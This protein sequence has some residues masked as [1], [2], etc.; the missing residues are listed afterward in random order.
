VVQIEREMVTP[1]PAAEVWAALT[2]AE[3]L[4]EWFGAAVEIDVRPGGRAMFRWDDGRT[5]GAVV[6]VIV[7]RRLLVMR[8]LPVEHDPAGRP[9]RVPSSRVRFELRPHA[10]GTLVRVSEGRSDIQMQATAG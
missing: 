5:R 7:P 8:W 10:E 1:A 2:R 6:E 4:S 9:F 3:R